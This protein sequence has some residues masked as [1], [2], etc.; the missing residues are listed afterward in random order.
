MCPAWIDRSA[1]NLLLPYPELQR[2]FLLTKA[3]GAKLPGLVLVKYVE[4][5][6]SKYVLLDWI[7]L[8]QCYGLFR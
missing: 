3:L 8:F 7:I 4:D 6:L 1:L 5:V 2:G